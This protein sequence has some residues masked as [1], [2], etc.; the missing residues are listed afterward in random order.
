MQSKDLT[1]KEL[2]ILKS[3]LNYLKEIEDANSILKGDIL[4]EEEKKLF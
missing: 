4:K 3:I 1:E 2:E